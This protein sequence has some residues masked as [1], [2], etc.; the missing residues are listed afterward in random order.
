[1]TI[2]LTQLLEK[3]TIKEEVKKHISGDPTTALCQQIF[4][5]E[6]I[7]YVSQKAGMVS[8]I[9]NILVTLG[10]NFGFMQTRL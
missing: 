9:A 10:Q 8:D 5:T 7:K 4:K 6:S 2:Q 1:M 3:I